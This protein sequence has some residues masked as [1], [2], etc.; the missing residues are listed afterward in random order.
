MT[1]K[2]KQTLKKISLDGPKNPN[3]EI[4]SR[5]NKA[6]DLWGQVRVSDD[7]Y[8]NASWNNEVKFFS[9]VTNA[10]KPVK[11]SVTAV[12]R[13]ILPGGR[14]V[15]W[16]NEHLESQDFLDNYIDHSRTLGK[17]DAPLIIQKQSRDPKTG[18]PQYVPEVQSIETIHEFNWVDLREQLIQWYDGKVEGVSFDPDCQFIVFESNN[19]K[20]GCSWSEFRDFTIQD[21]ILATKYGKRLDGVLSPSDAVAL[22]KKSLKESI[23]EIN[24]VPGPS[25][26]AADKTI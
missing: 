8:L 26:T 7:F 10:Q 4:I 16:F 19:V 18:A 14:E 13:K 24:Q 6:P 21:C 11:H 3:K 23:Q 15:A 17:F 9:T 2:S 20:Y 25:S 1:T 12:Y 5:Y 22:I